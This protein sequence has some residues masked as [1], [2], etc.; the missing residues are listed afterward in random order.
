M[1]IFYCPNA[2]LNEYCEL[3]ETESRHVAN[4]LRKREGEEL[5]IFD[6]I[7]N[8]YD[9]RIQAIG[10]KSVTLH[11]VRLMGKEESNG[12]KLHIAIAPPK[13]IERLEWFAEKVTEIGITEITP[14]LCKHS[15]RKEL[16][17]ERLEKILLGACKQSIKLTIPKLNPMV[18][19]SDFVN[20]RKDDERRYIAY[21]DE[22]AVHLKDAYHGGFDAVILIGPEGDFTKEEVL[23]AEKNEFETVSL[24]KSR[25]RLE[26][27][28]IFAAT[29]FNLA[30]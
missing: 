2:V 13:N 20:A 4:V 27:A 26:T 1:N 23:L 21:C 16:R 25:L 28:G 7:G 8:L 15:E 24:G 30:N 3:D 17:L 9:T 29:V 18:K 14:I 6:G 19:L 11:V 12:P 5:F 10:K 22:K